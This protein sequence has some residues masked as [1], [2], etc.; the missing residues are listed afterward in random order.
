M[1]MGHGSTMFYNKAIMDRQAE[2]LAEKGFDNIYIGY[3]ESSIPSISEILENMVNDGINEIV[4]L[5]FFIASGLHMT[6]DIPKKLGLE[7]NFPKSVVSV[8]GKDVKLYFE[9]PFGNDPLLTNIL[10]EKII[11]LCE[12]KQSLGIMI[13]GH[14]SKL[15]YNSEVMNF[16]A[17]RL[18]E[19]GYKTYIGFNEMNHP[20][21]DE[22]MQKMLDD[23]MKQIIVLPLF[24]AAGKHLIEDV[25]PRLHL[26]TMETR[27]VYHYD[28]RDVIISYAL[29]IG[30]DPRLSDI[31]AEKIR[32][33]YG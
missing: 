3:N 6:R 10:K 14:G 7:T 29:P 17:D 32:K 4:C 8:N 18:R 16:H 20:D 15:P 23:G 9:T 22:T 2:L 13:I 24:I 12:V 25:P 31:L 27:G 11:E 28:G 21:I 1:I 26:S 5:P 33:Y 19:M 30:S